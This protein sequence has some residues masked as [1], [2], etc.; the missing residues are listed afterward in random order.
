[1]ALV[2][3]LAAAPLPARGAG[4]PDCKSPKTCTVYHL[5]QPPIRWRAAANGVVRIPY[6]IFPVQPRMPQDR[7]IAAIRAAVATWEAYNPKVRF[8]Y[9]GVRS[10]PPRLG[11]GKNS[12]GFADPVSTGVLLPTIAGS[13]GW[14]VDSEYYIRE[15]DVLLNISTNWTWDPCPP[16]DGGCVDEPL[17]PVAD[18]L[19][20]RVVYAWATPLA[21]TDLQGVAAHELGHLLGLDHPSAEYC[22]LTMA[23]PGAGYELLHRRLHRGGSRSGGLGQGHVRPARCRRRPGREAGEP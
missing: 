23:P 16:R 10:L 17:W 3:L 14:L 4:R 11:D 12:I 20:G 15:S 6:D 7:A 13:A 1:L 18:P 5:Y 22:S 9:L 2:L 19:V 21:Q 8:V